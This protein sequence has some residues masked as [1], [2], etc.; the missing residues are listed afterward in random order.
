MSFVN[1]WSLVCYY[2]FESSNSPITQ[3][4]VE[5]GAQ[6]EEQ[7]FILDTFCCVLSSLNIYFCYYRW[8]DVAKQNQ[9]S[10]VC[11]DKHRN[12]EVFF[13]ITIIVQERSKSRFN[14]RLN[15]PPTVQNCAVV[16]KLVHD[17]CKHEWITNTDKKKKIYRFYSRRIRAFASYMG[18]EQTFFWFW[19][20]RVKV[21]STTLLTHSYPEMVLFEYKCNYSDLRDVSFA[22]GGIRIKMIPR[23]QSVEVEWWQLDKSMQVAMVAPCSTSTMEALWY[24]RAGPEALTFCGLG[25][26]QWGHYFSAFNKSLQSK[27][28][29][30]GC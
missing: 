22:S 24:D 18:N 17:Y 19:P 11:V 25:P 1:H 15:M 14:L 21:C 13:E 3:L 12:I 23:G 28:P 7:Y 8:K 6:V 16:M 20:M 9:A 27:S 10:G 26:T 2:L 5:M 4:S 29:G 30:P